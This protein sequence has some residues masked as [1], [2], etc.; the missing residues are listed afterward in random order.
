LTYQGNLSSSVELGKSNFHK[1]AQ[2]S[3]GGLRYQKIW[4]SRRQRITSG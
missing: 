4:V 1:S 3:L 2:Q